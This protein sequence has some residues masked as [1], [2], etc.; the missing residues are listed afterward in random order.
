[1][2][3][4][5]HF[6]LIILL[7]VLFLFVTNCTDMAPP[8]QIVSYQEG[9]HNWGANPPEA[10]DRARHR[11]EGK[12]PFEWWYFDGHLDNGQVFVGV[13]QVP[14]FVTGKIEAIFSLYSQD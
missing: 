6:K 2:S 11:I 10:R 4:T 1:M 9:I 5:Q 8:G 12:K 3:K 14:S 7:S 13:F